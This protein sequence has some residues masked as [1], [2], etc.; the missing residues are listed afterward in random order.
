MEEYFRNQAE[1]VHPFDRVA[2]SFDESEVHGTQEDR[3]AEQERLDRL[4]H[5]MLMGK[6]VGQTLTPEEYEVLMKPKQETG[7]VL[8]RVTDNRSEEFFSRRI[9]ARLSEEKAEQTRRRKVLD[10]EWPEEESSELL[11]AYI[12]Q[13]DDMVNSDEFRKNKSKLLKNLPTLF[14]YLS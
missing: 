14:G 4:H 11:R 3:E 7:S 2:S 5:Q 6:L 10:G 8:Q 9:L 12:S 13:K 1:G